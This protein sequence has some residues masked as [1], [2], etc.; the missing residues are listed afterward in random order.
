MKFIEVTAQ[1]G[2]T[3][4]ANYYEVNIYPS[5]RTRNPERSF[6]GQSGDEIDK[7]VPLGIVMRYLHLHPVERVAVS[8]GTQSF[9]REELEVLVQAHNASAP[10]LEQVS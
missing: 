8:E 2:I 4:P 3:E 1:S 7:L 6:R 5:P 9:I 10:M